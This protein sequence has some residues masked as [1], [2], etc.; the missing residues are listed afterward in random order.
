M[1]S[2]RDCHIE[3]VLQSLLNCLLLF[4]NH[5]LLFYTISSLA[6]LLLSS[7]HPARIHATILLKAT[8]LKLHCKQS[9]G[10][11]LEGISLLFIIVLRGCNIPGKAH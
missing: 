8:S 1:K 5:I 4:L 2:E 9:P 3:I 6:A 7:L 10:L 11:L